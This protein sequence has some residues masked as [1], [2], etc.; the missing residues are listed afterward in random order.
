MLN[1]ELFII[2]LFAAIVSALLAIYN[3][4]F[5]PVL[6]LVATGLVIDRLT[7]VRH[8]LSDIKNSNIQTLTAIKHLR[9]KSKSGVR[10]GLF[11]RDIEKIDRL[12]SQA[13]RNL[14]M[15]LESKDKLEKL[16]TQRQFSSIYGM[17]GVALAP[18]E[19]VR[20]YNLTLSKKPKVI[21]EAGS[22]TSSLVFASAMQNAGVKGK[23]YSLEHEPFYAEK[24]REMLRDAGVDTYVTVFDA[25]LEKYSI[26]KNNWLWFDK[27][28]VSRLPEGIDI[29]FV[30]SP[31]GGIQSMSRYPALP[32]LYSKLSKQ[33]VV[34]VDDYNRQDEKD[35]VEL[36][37][38]EYPEFELEIIKSDHGT[39]VLRR[40]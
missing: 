13:E 25:P 10:Q 38:K 17:R 18:D 2:G 32:I 6:I 37:L 3:P 27:E 14:Y 12:I 40:F 34:V 24:T 19:A 22:G 11:Q 36:W 29:L 9:N 30:D 28:K 31:P 16:L 15:Q 26:K 7:H 39:A 1:R 35:M 4:E 23:I 8:Q 21:V 5:I 33:A 20:L